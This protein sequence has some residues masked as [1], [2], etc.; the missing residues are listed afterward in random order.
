MNPS[1]LLREATAADIPTLLW[2]IHNAFAEYEG[3]LDPPSGAHNETAET[4][5]N[6]LHSGSAALASINGEIAGCVF[7]YPK[8]EYVYIGR[9]AVL[10]AFRRFGVGR[11]LMKYAEQRAGDVGFRRV[12]IGVRLA[13]PHLHAYYEGLGYSRVRDESHPGYERPT[14]TVMEKQIFLP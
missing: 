13:L 4:L 11:R 9:L 2:L 10:P 3:Q 14:Y 1:I 7:Y 5:S 8:D 6:A 12:Q